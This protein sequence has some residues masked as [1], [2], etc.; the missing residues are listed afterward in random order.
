M[1]RRACE[2]KAEIVAQDEREHGRRAL[3]NLGHTFGHAI[4][5]H[6]GYGEWLHGEA[7]AAGTCMAAAFSQRFGAIDS[8]IVERIRRLFTRLK[9]PVDPPPVDPGKFLA[10]MGMDKKVVAGQ[11]R[12]VLLERIGSGRITADYAPHDLADFLREQFVR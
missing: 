12:L 10:A 6:A 11:I 8:A 7:V 9:L 4:E 2:L 5:L 3:L 1:I